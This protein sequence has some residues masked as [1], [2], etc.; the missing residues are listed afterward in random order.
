MSMTDYERAV[1]IVRKN[2]GMAYFAGPR[3]EVLVEAAE[4]ELGLRFPPIY[5]RFLLDF[6][7]GSFGSAEI[8]GVIH[9]R[10][11]ESGIPDGVWYNMRLRR[12]AD[13]PDHLIAFYDVGDGYLY[14]ID[15]RES[16]LEENQIIGIE[17]ANDGIARQYDK[18]GANFGEVFLRLVLAQMEM[19]RE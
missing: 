4:Q 19:R 16:Q 3:E 11:E 17:L 2:P 18:I 10:F 14:C 6:G 7:A 12:E 5:R 13:F 1:E 9:G 8:Y 15:V